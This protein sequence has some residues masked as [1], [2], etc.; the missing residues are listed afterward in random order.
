[1]KFVLGAFAGIVALVIAVIGIV[2]AFFGGFVAGYKIRESEESDEV[3]S[4][5]STTTEESAT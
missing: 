1:V 3:E 2:A 5:P 4:T